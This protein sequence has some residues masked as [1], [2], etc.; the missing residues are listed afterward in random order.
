M[1]FE[2]IIMN[3][4]ISQSSECDCREHSGLPL[5]S[6]WLVIL[7]LEFCIFRRALLVQW[8]IE[9]YIALP[10]ACDIL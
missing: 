10:N 8:L 7:M 2:S 6:H 3:L 5:S 1:L 9:Y 4:S